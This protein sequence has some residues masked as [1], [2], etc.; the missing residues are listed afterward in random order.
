MIVSDRAT[1]HSR[2]TLQINSNISNFGGSAF[3][4]LERTLH[5]QHHQLLPI[6]LTPLFLSS[7][8]T[9]FLIPATTP[10]FL[11]P[12]TS[13][14]LYPLRL[15]QQL[16]LVHVHI[17]TGFITTIF[18]LLRTGRHNHTTTYGPMRKPKFLY[19]QWNSY[20]C[21]YRYITSTLQYSIVAAVL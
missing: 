9:F 11:S 4:F 21:I 2:S 10:L 6:F 7:S 15:I 19:M 13:L 3:I 8:L 18:L 17:T 20:Y 14:S 5:H 1:G 16:Q 12:P